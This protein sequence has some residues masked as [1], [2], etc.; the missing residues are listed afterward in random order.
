M[1]SRRRLY[2]MLQS[3]G[4]LLTGLGLG[5]EFGDACLGVECL[6]QP[7]CGISLL[8]CPT[9]SAAWVYYVFQCSNIGVLHATRLVILGEVVVKH[10][11]PPPSTL[12][13]SKEPMATIMDPTSGHDGDKWIGRAEMARCLVFGGCELSEDD[14][15]NGET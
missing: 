11:K 4:A 15:R 14:E 8:L 5:T 9:A 7:T 6:C 10:P 13:G 12:M 3:P 2:A 1:P